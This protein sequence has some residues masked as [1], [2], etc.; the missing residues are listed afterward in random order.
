MIQKKFNDQEKRE[1]EEKERKAAANKKIMARI[2]YKEWKERNLEE[3]RQRRKYDRMQR[4]EQFI[5][6]GN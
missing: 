2:A 6:G 5:A 1:I 3:D 4:R